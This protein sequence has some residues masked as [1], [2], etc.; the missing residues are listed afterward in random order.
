MVGGQLRALPTETS[1]GMGG[2]LT[3]SLGVRS[4]AHCKQ[5]LDGNIS[6]RLAFVLLIYMRLR[7]RWPRKI[8]FTLCIKND[9][10]YATFALATDQQ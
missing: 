10:F 5:L 3:R 4:A 7:A 8:F 1:G 6:I 2:C 9:H